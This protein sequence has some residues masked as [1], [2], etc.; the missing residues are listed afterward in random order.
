MLCYLKQRHNSQKSNLTAGPIGAPN[1]RGPVPPGAS[2]VRSF[3]P[4]GSIIMPFLTKSP[5]REVKKMIGERFLFNPA[6]VEYDMDF[7]SQVVN[8]AID[9]SCPNAEFP[10]CYLAKGMY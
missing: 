5:D 1:L 7:W 2:A 4:R 6:L 10:D 9:F 8:A 3:K